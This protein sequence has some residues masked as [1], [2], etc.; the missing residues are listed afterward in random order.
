MNLRVI[1]FSL[2]LADVISAVAVIY[3]RHQHRQGYAA[4]T[5]LTRE[6][7]QLNIEFGRLQLE[8]ATLAES[9]RVSQ[10]AQGRLRMR[11]P[12]VDDII[13]VRP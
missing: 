4:L 10:I 13:L 12:G 6:R 2:L 9:Q 8:Q 1:V 7:D 11:I 3:A 5:R